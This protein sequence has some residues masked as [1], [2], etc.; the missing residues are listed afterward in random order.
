[1]NGKYIQHIITSLVLIFFILGIDIFVEYNVH[2]YYEI[3][4]GQFSF[5]SQGHY[6]FLDLL[7]NFFL[8]T[9]YFVSITSIIF[10]KRW[11]LK[12]QTL[13][14][15]KTKQ[16]Q[17]DLSMLK[18]RVSAEFLLDKLNKVAE[19]CKTFPSKVSTILFQ[20]SRVLRYQLYDCTRDIVLLNSEIKFLND[21][22]TLEKICND[23]FNFKVL[24]PKTQKIF[25]VPPLLFISLIEDSLSY[26]S[27]QKENTWIDITFII[28]DNHLTFV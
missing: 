2:Q 18:N 5:F 20:L 26:L 7:S 9:L 25:F 6:K 19:C 13:E 4:F 27:Q 23:N 22:L 8:F 16:L 12:T 17:T 11:L 1:M 3:L 21:Y 10:Y 14:Q 15:L 28:V 24:Y